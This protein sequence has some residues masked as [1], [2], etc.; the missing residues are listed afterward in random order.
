[1]EIF[2]NNLTH[3]Y[4]D[5]SLFE[6][7]SFHVRTGQKVCIGGPSG[8][9]KSTLLKALMGFV[10]PTQG[11]IRIGSEPL[12]HSSVWGLRR[13]IA[14]VA[15]EPDLGEGIVIDRVRLPFDYHA[16][17]YLKWDRHKV[18]DYCQQFRLNEKLLHKEIRDLSGGEKQRIALMIALLLQRP[19]LLL[20][21]PVSALDKET[22]TAVKAELAADASRTVLFVSHESV[23]LEIADETINL[24]P[25]GVDR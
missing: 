12:T 19:I 25:M 10:V 13:R 11:E 1:M 17:A 4:D 7:L 15:Q 22:R 8:S 9:G 18:S 16:N 20:D 3:S 6:N 2:V 14:Y 5:Q 23:L 21:E 24:N